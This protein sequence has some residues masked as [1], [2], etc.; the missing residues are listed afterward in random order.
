MSIRQSSHGLIGI[1]LCFVFGEVTHAQTPFASPSP[2][3]TASSTQSLE[4]NFFKNILRDQRAIWTSPIH[5]R[6]RDARWLAPLGLA[7]GALIATDRN[8]ASA[9]AKFDDQVNASRVVS[10]VGSTYG[11]GAIAATF[12]FVGRARHNDRAH[13]TGLLS[14][15]ALIDSELL[16]SGLKAI[17]ERRRPLALLHRG[18]FFKGGTSFPSGHSIHAWSVAT[19]IAN[20]YHDDRFVQISAYGL[21]SLVS[22]ARYT[23]EKH[24]LSDVLVGSAMGY[25]IGRYVYHTHHVRNS[26]SG[27][28]EEEDA[29][30]RSKRWPAIAPEFNRRAH[31]YSLVLAWTF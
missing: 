21:A 13:E 15:E 19:V 20:E 31:E 29:Q 3:P 26:A 9:I 2:T 1:V 23:G 30:A 28:N 10:Y 14:A 16:V 5:L 8:T 25:G 17:T 11:A 27:G 12:Y 6:G 4:H 18:D 7:T 24:F 22:I